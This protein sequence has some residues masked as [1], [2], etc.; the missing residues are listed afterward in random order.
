M[1]YREQLSKIYKDLKEQKSQLLKE[2]AFLPEGYVNIRSYNNRNYYTWQIPK[3][4]KQKK[5]SRKGITRNKDQINKLV[6]KRYLDGAI[7]NIEDDILMMENVL[8]EYKDIDEAAV[9]RPFFQ[10]YPELKDGIHYGNMTNEEWSAD[11]RQVV[12]LYEADLK[13]T[14]S[15][16]RKMRS[17]GELLIS[18]RL[19]FYGIPY[20][21]EE[22]IDHPGVN[23]VPDF[24]IRRPRDGK[25]F[26]WEHMGMIEEGV[27]LDENIRKIK[28]YAAIGIT[29]WDNLIITF[30]QADGGM[31][32]RKI[33]AIIQGWLL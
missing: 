9:M 2:R 24:T 16:G 19:D 10:K 7:A 13:S 5:P 22:R 30:G 31:D 26:Y 3:K 14:S 32:V 6:R 33:D 1:V 8:K 29:P 17:Y 18:S 27:Y 15:S 28:Q 4:G 12:G 11:Y 23:R 25:I 21:Y 20:R